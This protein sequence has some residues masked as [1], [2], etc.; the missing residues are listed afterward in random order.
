MRQAL[1]EELGRKGNCV[2][3]RC[4]QRRTFGDKVMQ[5]LVVVFMAPVIVVGNV[6]DEGS[7]IFCYSLV[8]LPRLNALNASTL[9]TPLYTPFKHLSYVPH[10]ESYIT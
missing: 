10:R 3:I 6:D 7:E 1:D 9:M 8:I 5:F 4:A 2:R